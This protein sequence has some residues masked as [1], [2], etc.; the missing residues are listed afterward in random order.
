MSI[1][2]RIVLEILE[3]MVYLTDNQVIHKDLK[4]ENIL[5]DEHFHIKVEIVDS[6]LGNQPIRTMPVGFRKENKTTN[7]C[8]LFIN[9][10][11][12]LTA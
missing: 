7:I 12:Y 8:L 3:G 5:V 2:G 9:V 1:K 10:L 11:Y 4:P 6:G